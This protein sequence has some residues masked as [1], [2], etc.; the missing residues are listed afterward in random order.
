MKR[1]NVMSSWMYTE[2][3]LS[4]KKGVF[5]D[6]CFSTMG[7]DPQQLPS[8]HTEVNQVLLGQIKL[9]SN[10]LGVIGTK[11]MKNMLLDFKALI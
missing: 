1:D 7:Q 8:G 11:M 5:C 6:K 9:K 3:F 10:Y 4:H 2:K